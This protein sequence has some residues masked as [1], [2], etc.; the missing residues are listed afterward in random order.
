MDR[1]EAPNSA[2]LCRRY[3]RT[4]NASSLK[5]RPNWLLEDHAIERV[6]LDLELRQAEELAIVDEIGREELERRRDDF[7]VSVGRPTGL[8]LNL[9]AR[10]A[11]ACSILELGTGFGYSTIWLAEAA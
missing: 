11:N 9:M 1:H 10:G 4:M 8:V 2:P 3:S 7:L 6:L 5:Q